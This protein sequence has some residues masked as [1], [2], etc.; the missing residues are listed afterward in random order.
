AALVGSRSKER[1]S[2]YIDSTDAK[3][4]EIAAS[5]MIPTPVWKS[6]Y[7]LIFDQSAQPTLEGWAIVDNTTGDDWTNVRLALVSGRPI[8]FVSLL[9]EPKYVQRQLAELPDDRAA[10]PVVH[11]GEI[12]ELKEEAAGRRDALNKAM[13]PMAGLAAPAQRGAMRAGISSS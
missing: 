10:R 1:R 12:A 2:L 11:E 13:A 9:Y 6:S 5:Y 4:R 8:S 7:R 3:S